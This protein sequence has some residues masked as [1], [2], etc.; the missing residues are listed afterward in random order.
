M[1]TMLEYAERHTNFPFSPLHL[2]I[3]LVCCWGW[4]LCLLYRAL[5]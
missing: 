4:L 2:A 5:L 3:I 1:R